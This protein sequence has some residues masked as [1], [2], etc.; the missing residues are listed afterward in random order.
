MK[1]RQIGLIVLAFIGAAVIVACAPTVVPSSG[2]ES[3]GQSTLVVWSYTMDGCETCHSREAQ[4]MLS[5][6]AD[7]ACI[8]CH[9]DEAGLAAIHT[10]DYASKASPR[11]LKATT[12]DDTVCMACHA[13]YE[14][15]APLTADS[16]YLID[17]RGTIINPH[18]AKGSNAN[19]ADS[20]G[21][22][23]AKCHTQHDEADIAD[24]AIQVCFDCH[25]EKVFECYTC[26]D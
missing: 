3:S 23:C 2:M 24:T 14:E 17:S 9:R 6:H 19:H 1:K 20:A 12:V 26:H 16:S 13:T 7:N 21:I 5:V 15:L 8:T 18:L 25:H 11:I 4:S 22:S 10:G